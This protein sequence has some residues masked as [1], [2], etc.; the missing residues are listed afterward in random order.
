[1]NEIIISIK[2]EWCR[3]IMTGQKNNDRAENGRS[4]TDKAKTEHA[5]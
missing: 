3:K 2:P 1:M 4:Q 5:F